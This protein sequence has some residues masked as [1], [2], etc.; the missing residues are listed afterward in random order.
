M[1]QGRDHNNERYKRVTGTFW[2]L[3]VIRIIIK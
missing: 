3:L 1:R 2:E